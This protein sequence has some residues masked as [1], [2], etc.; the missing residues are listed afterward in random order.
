MTAIDKPTADMDLYSRH[1]Q[2]FLREFP[3]VCTGAEWSPLEWLWSV[4]WL[5]GRCFEQPAFTRW[6]CR[7]QM[8]W[9]LKPARARHGEEAAQAS[10]SGMTPLLR[11]ARADS[12]RQTRLMRAYLYLCIYIVVVRILGPSLVSHNPP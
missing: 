4:D 12:T 6:Q 7:M 5:L 11:R 9:P 10:T 8:E 1:L 3:L 2:S